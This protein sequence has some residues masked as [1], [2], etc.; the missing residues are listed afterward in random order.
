MFNSIILGLIQGLTEFFP[1]SS[2]A[3]VLFFEKL[4]NTEG[5]G[6]TFAAGIHLATSLAIIIYFWKDIWKMLKSLLN[7]KNE[8]LKTDRQLAFKIILSTI[9]V[10]IIGVIVEKVD[11]FEKLGENLFVM[12]TSLIVFGILLYV[13]DRASY[14]NINSKKEISYFD[15]LV[16]G[17]SQIIAAIF[18]GASRSGMTLT[19]SFWRNIDREAATKFIFL[20]AIPA[21]A[22]PGIYEIV[23]KKTLVINTDFVFAFVAAF[24]SGLFA[25]YFLLKLIQKNSLKW[26][27]LYR[28]IF[29]LCIITFALIH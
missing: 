22:L 3:H 26:F 17:S 29:G 10:I 1:V 9:P 21:T 20:I 12:G 4:L 16:I 15:S 28:I 6:K 2:S 18:P 5:S 11:F 19:T 27:C 24:L 25:I 13:V 14:K 8:T 7:F 23:I